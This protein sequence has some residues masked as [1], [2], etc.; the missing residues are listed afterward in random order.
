MLFEDNLEESENFALEITLRILFLFNLFL[1]IFLV[2][3]LEC[4]G[5]LLYEFLTM[6]MDS[7]GFIYLII[8]IPADLL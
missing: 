8:L 7:Y 5:F 1:W 3:I 2:W 6:L 4:Y